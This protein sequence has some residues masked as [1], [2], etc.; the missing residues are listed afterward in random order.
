MSY[1]NFCRKPLAKPRLERFRPAQAGFMPFGS[2]LA[3]NGYGLR[4]FRSRASRSRTVATL[5]HHASFADFLHHPQR[6]MP[7]HFDLNCQSQVLISLLSGLTKSWTNFENWATNQKMGWTSGG[8]T[9]ALVEG[10]WATSDISQVLA[11]LQEVQPLPMDAIQL[12]EDY[13]FLCFYQN[14][15]N[16]LYISLTRGIRTE[17][18]QKKAQPQ[19]TR[20]S[21]LDT[22]KPEDGDHIPLFNPELIIETLVNPPALSTDEYPKLCRDLA[23]GWIR[24][25][26]SNE[27]NPVKQWRWLWNYF[28]RALWGTWI[29]SSPPSDPEI[30]RA[31]EE[32]EPPVDPVQIFDVL[33]WL[34]TSP[35]TDLISA[36]ERY[37]YPET[38]ET[39][40]HQLKHR[41]T[42]KTDLTEWISNH[43]SSL[44][45]I[46]QKE[47]CGFQSKEE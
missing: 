44:V 1:T 17:D 13:H 4:R 29:R 18:S 6:C 35:R 12:W 28:S 41:E 19:N 8:T 38:R 45:D 23:L 21:C 31:L 42:T 32:W 34:Q 47:W 11:W 24:I 3:S 20:D 15:R 37:L 7:L 46:V 27:S 30:I 40:R 33:E 16:A 43:H 9:W 36:W 2:V 39:L 10:Q 25:H 22:E 26:K 5:M 14:L